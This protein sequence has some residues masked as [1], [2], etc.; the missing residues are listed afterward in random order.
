V[1]KLHIDE[2]REVKMKKNMFRN[3][4]KMYFLYCSFLAAALALHFKDDLKSLRR[5]SYNIL[6]HSKWRRIEEVLPK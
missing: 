3:P 5:R 2:V 1:K 6:N 4:Q